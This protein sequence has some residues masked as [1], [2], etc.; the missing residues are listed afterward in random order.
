M[1]TIS[2][3]HVSTK[4]IVVGGGYA[5]FYTAWG[6]ER[7]LRRGEASVTVIDPAP[8]M[9]ISPSSPRSLPAR[10]KRDTRS[11]RCAGT[12]AVPRSSA[13]APPPSTTARAP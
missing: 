4:R 1:K 9:T 13:A 11:S 2:A 3:R 6:L 5:G 8:Y 7:R 12:C 10:S